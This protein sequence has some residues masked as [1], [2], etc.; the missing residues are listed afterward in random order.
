MRNLRAVWAV[1]VDRLSQNPAMAALLGAL[2]LV[3]IEGGHAH[4][5]PVAGQEQI[6]GFAKN[7]HRQQKIAEAIEQ[8]V[9]RPVKVVFQ[10]A[11]PPETPETS[12]SEAPSAAPAGERTASQSPRA[13]L[14]GARGNASDAAPPS[15]QPQPL[16]LDNVR[17]LPLVNEVLKAFPDA[18]VMGMFTEA[19]AAETPPSEAAE[20]HADEPAPEPDDEEPS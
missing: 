6:A 7:E 16:D 19:P 12:P 1:I 5:A 4:V 10:D 18:M 11:P 17:K 15:Q 9:G 8:V 20:D 3:K 13:P 14:P 2:T